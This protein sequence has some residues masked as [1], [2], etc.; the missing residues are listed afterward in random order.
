MGLR[1]ASASKKIVEPA[2]I[3]LV[4]RRG[5]VLQALNSRGTVGRGSIALRKSRDAEVQ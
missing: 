1:D 5:Q 3:Q 2:K 4:H